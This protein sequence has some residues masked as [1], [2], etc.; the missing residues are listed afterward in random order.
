MHVHV[1]LEVIRDKGRGRGRG[2]GKR[3]REREGKVKGGE[4]LYIINTFKRN[5]LL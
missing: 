1:L 5:I 4:K 2:R 3:G